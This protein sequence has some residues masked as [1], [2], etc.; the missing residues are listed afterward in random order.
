MLT[1]S[2]RFTDAH[3]RRL[4]KIRTG[5][6]N[7]VLQQWRTTGFDSPD[8]DRTVKLVLAGQRAMV[9]ATDADLSAIAGLLTNTPTAPI[10]LD[11]D[12]LIGRHARNGVYLE[13]VYARPA[14][15]A[16]RSGF[17]AGVQ[18][19]RQAINLDSQV[20][21]RRAANALTE[22]DERVIGWRR[23]VN[24]GAGKVCGLC[25]AASAQ[26]YRK[27]DLLPLHPMC[28]CSVY[29]V[30]TSNPVRNANYID[31]ERLDEVYARSGGATDRSTLGAI[32][33][34]ADELPA[35]IDTE[36]INDLGARVAWH[37]EIGEYLTGHRH[38]TQFAV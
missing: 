35:G 25:V 23:Q 29:S 9:L 17:D 4:E 26:M 34:T 36:A 8:I 31:R 6:T 24:P 32:R 21:Q 27:Q 13:D 3:W 1:P 10:G 20:A 28:R 19:L 33:F 15:V 2:S 18:Y 16:R 38:D 11:P 14:A 22:A 37:P 12:R 30:L 5:M 7:A